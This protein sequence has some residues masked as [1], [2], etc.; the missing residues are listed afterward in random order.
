MCTAANSW[1]NNV[2]LGFMTRRISFGFG[3]ASYLGGRSFL[4]LFDELELGLGGPGGKSARSHCYDFVIFF[5]SE[6]GSSV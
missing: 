3:S 5:L 4:F 6:S 1:L 2:L